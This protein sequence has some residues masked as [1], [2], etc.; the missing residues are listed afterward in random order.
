MMYT[1][2]A[3]IV[4]AAMAAGFLYGSGTDTRANEKEPKLYNKGWYIYQDSKPSE[5]VAIPIDDESLSDGPITIG[6]VLT[7]EDCTDGQWIM[8]IGF[9]SSVNICIDGGMTR[10]MIYHDDYGWEYKLP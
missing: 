3:V 7:K 8:F 6:R 2:S 1:L 9:H 5:E 10:L 4:F